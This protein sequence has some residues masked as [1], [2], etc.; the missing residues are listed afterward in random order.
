M[1]ILC[2]SESLDAICV[3]HWER[4]VRGCSIQC[5]NAAIDDA[6]GVEMQ[7]VHTR[8]ADGA[9]VDELI[10]SD[11]LI[12]EGGTVMATI[13]LR[14]QTDLFISRLVEGELLKPCLR[15]VPYR[16]LGEKSEQMQVGKR[17]V[18]TAACVVELAV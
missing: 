6:K 18:R 3:V 7:I 4:C 12:D 1:I 8:T 5:V 10:A 11:K 14:K 9:V 13:A 2:V 17:D 15:K 16:D